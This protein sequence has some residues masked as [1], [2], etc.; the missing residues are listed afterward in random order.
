MP[1]LVG[2]DLVFRGLLNDADAGRLNPGVRPLQR[3]A[4]EQDASR[5]D[6]VGR[7]RGLQLPQQRG[8]SAA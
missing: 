4:A 7:E 5:S 3:L 6:A 1:H 2:D 8:L